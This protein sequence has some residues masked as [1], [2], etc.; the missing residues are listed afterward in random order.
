[1][2]LVGSGGLQRL[3]SAMRA[4]LASVEIQRLGVACLYSVLQL[5]NDSEA[6]WWE[7]DEEE[8]GRGSRAAA[9]GQVSKQPGIG[10]E[11]G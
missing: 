11:G 5:R 6:R 8:E 7:E 2:L 9:W 1:M 4:H 3:L 10:E